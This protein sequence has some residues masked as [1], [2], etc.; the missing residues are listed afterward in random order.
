MV[1]HYIHNAVV[2]LKPEN[3]CL[4]SDIAAVINHVFILLV[5]DVKRS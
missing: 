2:K 1:D 4:G 5:K 3:N